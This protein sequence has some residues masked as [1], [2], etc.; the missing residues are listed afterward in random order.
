MLL[1]CKQKGSI[2]CLLSKQSMRSERE[3]DRDRDRDMNF[4]LNKGIT[5]GHGVSI[6][7]D[8]VESQ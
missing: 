8:A 3:R 2:K 1:A 5:D 7:F 6:G 4:T